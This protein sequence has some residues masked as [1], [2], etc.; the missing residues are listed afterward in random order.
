MP[1]VCAICWEAFWAPKCPWAESQTMSRDIGDYDFVSMTQEPPMNMT[2]SSIEYCIT[3]WHEHNEHIT[4][5]Y[6]YTMN[7]EHLWTMLTMLHSFVQD[8][9]ELPKIRC[10]FQPCFVEKLV[11]WSERDRVQGQAAFLH[12]LPKQQELWGHGHLKCHL[13]FFPAFFPCFAIR[14]ITSRDLL[15]F[16]VESNS[17]VE[18]RNWTSNLWFHLDMCERDLWAKIQR[19]REFISA[20]GHEVW[21]THL[22]TNSFFLVARCTWLKQVW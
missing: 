9:L 20:S 18:H 22:T 10:T 19:L 12:G 17:D 21:K 15:S 7:Y 1:Q 16:V 14:D 5:I 4:Y 2:D 11:F 6:I 8:Y 3:Q 13:I